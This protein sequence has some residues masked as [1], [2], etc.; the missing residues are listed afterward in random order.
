MKHI[1]F[2][3]CVALSLNVAILP[4]DTQH[5]V[6]SNQNQSVSIQAAINE[7]WEGV[8]EDAR[9]PVV[10]SVDFKAK[11]ISLNGGS[12]LNMSP[13]SGIASVNPSEV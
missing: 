13:E 2:N 1:L 6:L 5:V 4:A 10:I 11:R 3:F 8:I 12:S 7:Q 9:R